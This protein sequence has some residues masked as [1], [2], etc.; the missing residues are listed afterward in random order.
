MDI[1]DPAAALLSNF[2]VLQLV[3]ESS[4]QL[5]GREV[6]TDT[7]ASVEN[8]NTVTYE[9]K[10]Y[11]GQ[12]PA[13]AQSEQV[14]IDFL[15]ALEKYPLTRFEKLQLLNFRPGSEVLFLRLVEEGEDRF[16]AETIEEILALIDSTLPAQPTEEAEAGE[17]PVEAIEADD[18]AMA[19][20][21]AEAED[22]MEEEDAPAADIPE[23]EL[24]N[25][26]DAVDSAGEDDE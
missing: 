22:Y 20:G 21:A 3:T 16:S 24:V 19:V 10:K 12:T 13:Q 14:V 15:Q 9:L 17:A 2:E 25:E 26:R 4:E 7:E 6:G 5:K 11:L 23:D 1:V 18:G 8:L